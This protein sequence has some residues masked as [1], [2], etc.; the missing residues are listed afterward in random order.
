MKVTK[1]SIAGFTL[2]EVIA[3][4]VIM[5]IVAVVASMGL[6]QGVQAYITTRINSETLQRAQFA[7][8]RMKLEFISMD[9]ITAASSSS[10]SFTS[11]NTDRGL[12]TVFVFTH[13][14]SQINLNVADSSNP[15][16]TGLIADG[17]FLSYVNNSGGAWT[18]GQGFSAL[19]HIVIRLAIPRSDGGDRAV[20]TTSVNPRNNGLANG[21]K[22]VLSGQ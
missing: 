20:F 14:G 8:N 2:I 21:P 3:S 15:L 22:P 18:A 7:L 12:G 16:L 1:K 11:N 5:S 10:I 9:S 6:I 19:H 17:T 4:L 13:T